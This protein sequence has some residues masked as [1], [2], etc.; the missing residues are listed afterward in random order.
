MANANDQQPTS[1][2]TATTPAESPAI[3]QRLDRTANYPY[4]RSEYVKRVL[5]NLVRRT[6]FR[7]GLPR[8]FGWRRW[9]LRRF[10]A[11]VGA[12]AFVRK[13]AWIWHPWL[14]EIGEHST[15]ADGVVIY[16]LGPVAI[17]DHSVL[18]QDVYVCAGTHDYTV[19]ELPLVRPPVRIGS[20]VWIAAQAFIGPG[21][22]VGDNSVVGARSVVM[23]DVPAGVV[24]AGNPAR[25]IKERPMQDA[26][27]GGSDAAVGG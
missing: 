5:W 27:N 14:F 19:P 24:V 6:L 8:A 4:P 13:D 16:N 1:T 10:G 17:G 21:V 26:G 3:F 12:T 18:S 25:V 15:L 23:K 9:L 22:T 7:W 2:G 11:R 20:G